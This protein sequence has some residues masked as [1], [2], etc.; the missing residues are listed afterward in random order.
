MKNQ[1]FNRIL[2]NINNVNTRDVAKEVH[3]IRIYQSSAAR[4]SLCPNCSVPLERE[5]INFCSNC[6]QML[7]WDYYNA[8][9]IEIQFIPIRK[10]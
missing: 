2:L 7:S 6:G 9:N 4:Y 8:N 10:K 1:L 3:T 5:Y